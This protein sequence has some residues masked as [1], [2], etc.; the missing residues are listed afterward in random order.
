MNA[1]GVHLLVSLFFVIGTM[2]EFA[3]VLLIKRNITFNADLT[4]PSE[5]RK[6]RRNHSRTGKLVCFYK[7]ISTDTNVDSASVDT[8]SV[9]TNSE[10]TNSSYELGEGKMFIS[11]KK[12]YSLTDKIDFVALFVFLLSYFMFNC[13]YTAHYM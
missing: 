3:I 1:L 9:D 13:I 7:R 2:I 11:Q 12:C 8:K 10:D 6:R 4:A 5:S